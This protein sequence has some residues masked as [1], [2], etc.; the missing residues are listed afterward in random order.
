MNGSG[1]DWEAAAN[2]WIDQEVGEARM[3]EGE[4]IAEIEEFLGRHKICAL[5]TA[6]AG[7]VRNTT[8]EYVHAEGA[9][10]I[11]SE[12]GLKF[13][14][15]QA[16]SNVCLV[17]HDEDTSFDTLAGLQVTGTAE[18]L[19][20]FGAEYEHACLLRGIPVERLRKLSFVMNIIKVVPTRYDYVNGRLKERGFSARQH[21]DL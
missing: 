7:I 1:I 4:L 20:P 8:V 12:G 3:P 2:H 14:A 6:G 19:E 5:A 10:W 18:V 21:V 11:V 13:R 16:N 9:F 15:L 17:I